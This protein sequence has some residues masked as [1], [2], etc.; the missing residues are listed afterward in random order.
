MGQSSVKLK[1]VYMNRM[2]FLGW[3]LISPKNK[4]IYWVNYALLTQCHEVSIKLGEVLSFKD[5]ALIMGAQTQQKV[6]F[7]WCTWGCKVEPKGKLSRIIYHFAA[8]IYFITYFTEST[9]YF[10]PLPFWT[11]QVNITSLCPPPSSAISAIM[12][13][14]IQSCTEWCLGGWTQ[15]AWWFTQS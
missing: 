15:Y 4:L 1:Y 6:K 5:G 12:V 13:T 9:L 2:L 8:K 14:A 11:L 10:S 7:V 3:A